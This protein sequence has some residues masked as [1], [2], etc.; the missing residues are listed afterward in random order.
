METVHFD[1]HSP[2]YRQSL[3]IR[4]D[5][6]VREQ[7]IDR[8]LEVDEYEA[9]CT[10]F[11]TMKNGDP[12]ATGRLRVAGKKIKFERIATLSSS[13]NS[14]AGTHLMKA[15]E[16]FARSQ[17]PEFTPFMHAQISAAG[18]YEKRGWTR[19]GEL[20]DEAG[21]PHVAMKLPPS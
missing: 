12:V 5:V 16:A 18:F 8:S 11:L 14:G 15:M 7:E 19:V 17:F 20:F 10:Y 6:F 4:E 3:A 1:L 21:I 2:Y 13:R 9:E